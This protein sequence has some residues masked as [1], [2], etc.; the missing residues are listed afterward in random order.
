MKISK[1]SPDL[2]TIYLPFLLKMCLTNTLSHQQKQTKD[3]I[4]LTRRTEQKSDRNKV[5]LVS[6]M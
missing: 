3:I 2:N 4:E 5:N 1:P 6:N